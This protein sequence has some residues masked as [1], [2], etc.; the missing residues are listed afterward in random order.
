MSALPI[1][2]PPTP[3]PSHAEAAAS[4]APELTEAHRAQL[5][6]ARTAFKPLRRALRVA[7]FSAVSLSVFAVLSL[8][9]ALFSFK[10]AF[11]AAGLIAAAVFEFRGRSALR[12]LEPA[13]VRILTWNQVALTATITIYCLWSM[14]TAW[15]GPDLYARV[16]ATDPA[17]G[18]LLAPYSDLFR[19]LI[20]GTYAVL[21]FVA[22]IVQALVIRYYATRGKHLQKYL[23]ETPAWV[24][25]WNRA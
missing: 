13:G 21:L 6:A 9:F 8:P 22:W 2:T 16:A 15:F 5:A 20:V 7:M 4:S 24:L 18:E 1:P 14:A 10:A 11:A 17:V 25:A 3:S 12:R 19:Q 23:T